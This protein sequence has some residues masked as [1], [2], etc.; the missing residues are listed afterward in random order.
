MSKGNSNIRKKNQAQYFSY[1]FCIVSNTVTKASSYKPVL[2]STG[3]PNSI[4]AW[5]GKF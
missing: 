4:K 3:F 5:D 1:H 2:L